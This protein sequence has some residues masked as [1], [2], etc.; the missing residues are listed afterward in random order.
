[1]WLCPLG[2]SFAVLAALMI[3]AP[4]YA[5]P[6]PRQM[7]GIPRPVDDLPSGSVSVRVI[8]G[9]MTNNI[10]NQTVELH[11][12][13]QVQTTKT[14]A[15]GRA[16][17]D[18]LPAG[19]TLKAT[20]DVDGERL[21]SQ[22]FP[23]PGQ[24]GIRLLL[25]ASGG[26]ADAQPAGP[27]AA[28][29]E[30]TI[31]GQSR[32]IIQPGEEIIT[33]YY[34]L[35]I[36]NN[37]PGPVNPTTPFAFDMPD[38]AAR[39]GVMQG[40]TALATVSGA[41]VQLSGPFPPGSSVVNI[42]AEIPVSSGSIDFEQRFPAALDNF[43][44]IVKKVGDT[45]IASPQI[46]EQREVPAQGELFIA[47]AGAPVPAGE[48]LKLSLTGIPH[49]SPTPRRIALALAGVILGLGLWA[50]TRP[51]SDSASVAAERKRLVA[52]REKL[53]AALVRLERERREAG[54]A[55]VAAS[56]GARREE[57]LAALEH[58]YGALDSAAGGD[59]R[60]PRG[61]DGRGT[62]PGTSA[63]VAA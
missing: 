55:A 61:P 57:I 35:E 53:L 3:A 44:V 24:G 13:G 62:E 34:L 4:L 2:R 36:V 50:G 33:V 51:R 29:G 8:R 52:R 49:H 38:G 18:K 19:A 28:A 21:E 46:T 47:G 30:V 9:A 59:P 39:T 25:V 56:Y 37:S 45:K 14:D 58:V 26:A 10:A 11:V 40:S 1:M 41:H 27:P 31:G 7:A 48:P 22:E 23:A 54:T 42:G 16:Q 63:G 15:Q 32:I 17:F 12:G 5:Q 6:D 20:A 60:D 43:A